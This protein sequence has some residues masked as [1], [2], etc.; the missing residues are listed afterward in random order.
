MKSFSERDMV[1]IILHTIARALWFLFTLNVV[2]F[3]FFSVLFPIIILVLINYGWSNRLEAK[4][5]PK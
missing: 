2:N 3:I 5:E 1:V 4:N